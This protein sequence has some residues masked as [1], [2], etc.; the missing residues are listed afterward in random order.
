MSPA[1]TSVAAKAEDQKLP[2]LIS[3]YEEGLGHAVRCSGTE[4][5]TATLDLLLLRDRIAAAL[6]D[7]LVA[8]AAVVEQICALD[9][10]LKTA[11]PALH[12]S[13]GDSQLTHWR[14]T[15]RPDAGA[16]W[17]FLDGPGNTRSVF[18]LMGP[19]SAALAFSILIALLADLM[20]RFL[21]DGPDVGSL[22]YLIFQ[23]GLAILTGT[24]F[25]EAGERW[26]KGFSLQFEL[27]QPALRTLKTTVLVLSLAVV[28]TVW[29][30][31][32]WIALRY[33]SEPGAQLANTG[34]IAAA[35]HV[36]QR[37]VALSPGL[38]AAHYN[39]G[40]V[41]EQVGEYDKALV[42]YQTTLHADGKHVPAYNGAARLL[43]KK[44]DYSGALQL[45]NVAIQ[46]PG[47]S[48]ELGYAVWKNRGAAQL[49]LTHILQAEADLKQAL[50]LKRDGAEAHC[51]MAQLF[52]A[53]G[54]P[55]AAES[56]DRCVNL[57][58]SDP[59]TDAE[60]IS[61]ALEK[62]WAREKK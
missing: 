60:L 7:P 35:T 49:R 22:S 21:A 2:E 39:L 50:E 29:C 61:T 5:A 58:A 46:E 52:E 15:I 18:G 45:L 34:Q 4:L 17:W 6:L 8:S 40:Y 13:L 62:I 55:R 53:R 30:S 42:E 36:L 19:F 3:R 25:T 32:D 54:D 12:D 44:K 33:Y 26:V 11:A 48:G 47:L 14:E 51:L 10:R 1:E 37:A 24:A 28:T 57:A 31:L 9:E 41:Y 16:W 20:R 38:A 59:K 43:I 23:T 56:Q 27:P